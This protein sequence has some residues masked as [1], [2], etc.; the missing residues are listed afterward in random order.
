MKKP[1]I[2]FLTFLAFVSIT[3]FSCD[4]LFGDDDED[5]DSVVN[6]ISCSGYVGPRNIDKQYDYQ[7]QAA[8]IYKCNGETENLKNQCA[9]YKLLQNQLNLPDCDYCD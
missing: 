1:K 3:F 6:T 9:Y 8:Y 5:E 4:E 2:L 7:C